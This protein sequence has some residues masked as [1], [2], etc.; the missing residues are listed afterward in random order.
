MKLASAL[1]AVIEAPI[2]TS[3]TRLGY[4]VRR[5]TDDWAPLDGYDMTGR[6]VVLTGATSGLGLAAARQLAVCGATIVLVGRSADKN[7]RVVDDLIAETGN[8]SLTQFAADMGDYDQVRALA[9]AVLADHDRLDVLTHNAGALSAERREALDG[10]EAT[11][12]SQVVG[13]FLLTSLL[14]DRL[15][16]SAPSRVLTMSSGGMYSTGLKMDELQMTADEYKGSGQYARAKR[17]QVTLNEMLAERLGDHGIHFHSLHPGWADTPGVR[18]AL[19]TFRKIVGPLLRTA[20]QGSDT[21]VW[22]AAD[23]A[24]LKSNGDFWHDR[25]TRNIH[26]LPTTRST[27]TPQRRQ[28]LWDWVVATSGI[29]PTTGKQS[30]A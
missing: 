14:L 5:R 11:V 1:D 4:D 17:A 13:P 12:A 30:G 6:V 26:K 7:Q 3:F 16:A 9:A 22:L 10:T 27:D 19:P 20:E 2:V 15:A 25:R 24:A 21:L 18:D 29:D 8:H 28:E 23:D